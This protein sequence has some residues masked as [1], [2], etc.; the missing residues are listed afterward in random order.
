M[1]IAYYPKLY[2][3]LVGIES[4]F[5]VKPSPCSLYYIVNKEIMACGTLFQLNSW[6]L[7]YNIPIFVFLVILKFIMM[8][9]IPLRGGWKRALPCL[10][11]A[12]YAGGIVGAVQQHPWGRR[13]WQIYHYISPT[14]MCQSDKTL[15]LTRW[16]KSAK[17]NLGRLFQKNII[18]LTMLHCH[19][20]CYR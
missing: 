17:S 10:G 16:V 6:N 2:W 13:Q 4:T 20:V 12:G 14:L 8:W 19:S 9:N 7:F 1:C 15:M 3:H 18:L 11:L 5:T